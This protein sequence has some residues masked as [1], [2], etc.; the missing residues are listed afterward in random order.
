MHIGR[1]IFY[2]VDDDVNL[3]FKNDVRSFAFLPFTYYTSLPHTT[4][5][6]PTVRHIGGKT[7]EEDEM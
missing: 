4:K 1:P 3:S 2:D 7:K 6:E 5:E